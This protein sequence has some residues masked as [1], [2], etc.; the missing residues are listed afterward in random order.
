MENEMNAQ[1]I[2]SQEAVQATPAP[3]AKQPGYLSQAWSELRN[4]DGFWRRSF[5]LA[6]I[7]LVPILNFT[8][9]G[10]LIDIANRAARG[11]EQPWSE[12]V[13]TSRNFL[14][15]FFLVI[16]SLILGVAYGLI[17]ILCAIPLVGLVVLLAIFVSFIFMPV[18][19]ELCGIRIALSGKFSRAFDFKDVFEA[20]KSGLGSLMFIEW[21]PGFI[22]F[23]IC[24]IPSFIFG[25]IA[26]VCC[27]PVVYLVMQAGPFMTSSELTAIVAAV[28]VA[29]TILFFVYLVFS[30]V[31]GVVSIVAQEVVY[32][33]YGLW[34]KKNCYNWVAEIDYHNA[35][36]EA[37][38]A[39]A[40]MEYQQVSAQPHSQASAQPNVQAQAPVIPVDSAGQSSHNAV[41]P[42]DSAASVAFVTPE[43]P[44]ASAAPVVPDAPV[45]PAASADQA[46]T[47][48]ATHSS[49]NN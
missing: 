10:S 39:A 35:T 46:T 28:G 1:A 21:I 12:K 19:A 13:I 34:I 36:I 29:V 22:V 8:V 31:L 16:F 33:A 3:E 30:Y 7:N 24:L 4:T 27:G 38:K 32:R 25:I 2:P 48:P 37:A 47:T 20:F 9:M 15:G 41:S 23:G 44:V 6:L 14:I 5:F 45:A 42:E 49:E 11:I 18:F 26:A 43:A 17:S 40:Q